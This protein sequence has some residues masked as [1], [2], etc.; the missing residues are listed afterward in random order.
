MRATAPCCS[1]RLEQTFHVLERTVFY[2]CFL[3]TPHSLL[4]KRV[5][6]GKYFMTF[7]LEDPKDT[8]K[9]AHPLAL[10]KLTLFIMEIMKVS[11]P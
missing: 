10:S 1:L 11:R 6:F 5:H 2:A 4:L 3:L 8:R 9:L 7:D